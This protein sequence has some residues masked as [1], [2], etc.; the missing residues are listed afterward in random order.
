MHEVT[1]S[2]VKLKSVITQSFSFEC[3]I[4]IAVKILFDLYSLEAI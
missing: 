3:D 2:D 4:K 1:Q